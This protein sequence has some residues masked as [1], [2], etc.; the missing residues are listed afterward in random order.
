MRPADLVAGWLQAGGGAMA[1]EALIGRVRGAT[2]EGCAEL[3][4]RHAAGLDRE[5]PLHADAAEALRWAAGLLRDTR[6]TGY[7]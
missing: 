4:E 6:R 1:L 2:V 3:L 7:P 5:G